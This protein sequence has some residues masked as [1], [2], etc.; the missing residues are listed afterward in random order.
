VN[1]S[2]VL[3]KKIVVVGSLTYDS[4]RLHPDLQ[5]IE[6]Y[7]KNLKSKDYKY[8]QIGGGGANIAI[9]LDALSKIYNIPVEITLC[10]H[11]GVPPANDKDAQET[12]EKVLQELEAHGIKIVDTLEGEENI[13][14]DNVVVAFGGKRFVSGDFAQATKNFN[15]DAYRRV[16]EAVTGADFAFMHSKLTPESLAVGRKAK[17]FNVPILLDYCEMTWPTDSVH[18]NMRRELLRLPTYIFAPKE[19]VIPGAKN[20]KKISHSQDLLWGIH[21]KF[22]TPN[23]A[24][25]NDT[26][27]VLV[28][29]D[30]QASDFPVRVPKMELDN[31][32]VGDARNAMMVLQLLRGKDFT[33]ALKKASNTASF[34]VSYAGRSWIKPLENEE[35]RKKLLG[36]TATT[37]PTH[38]I[39]DQAGSGA[40]PP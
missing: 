25:S 16:Q 2:E 15:N 30:G 12:R 34:S 27:P 20:I 37:N 9:N 7:K 13:I 10:T 8:K 33:T 26:D 24:V 17:E 18:Q 35:L 19:A 3:P 6:G 22:N 32:G 38:I 21:K 14:P 23:V 28:L 39:K 31:L 5:V 40:H 4:V 29:T 36:D 11:I 1:E